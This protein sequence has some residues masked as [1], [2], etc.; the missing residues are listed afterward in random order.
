VEVLTWAIGLLVVIQITIM[1]V[2]AKALWEHIVKCGRVGET[3][4]SM[5][6]DIRRIVSD[7][8]DHG[9]G[10]RGRVHKQRGQIGMLV[11]QIDELREKAGL[12]PLNLAD[13]FRKDLD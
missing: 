11:G 6:S 12:R 8:G 1:G 5:A 2:V 9:S 3:L 10:L 4:G 13:S 7:V